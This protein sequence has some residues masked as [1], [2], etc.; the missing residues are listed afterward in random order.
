M[1]L[2]VHAQVHMDIADT[3]KANLT[4]LHKHTN[5]HIICELWM[6]STFVNNSYTSKTLE[7]TVN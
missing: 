7:L 6:L 3:V 5:M 1:Q 2:T 4:K